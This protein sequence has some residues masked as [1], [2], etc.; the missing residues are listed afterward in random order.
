MT[1]TNK[2][3][4]SKKDIISKNV[5]DGIIVDKKKTFIIIST[6]KT[7]KD[8]KVFINPETVYSKLS[9]TLPNK[10]ISQVKIKLSDIKID[11]EVSL[12][13]DEDKKDYIREIRQIIV[14]SDENE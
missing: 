10:V 2:I 1:K 14:I 9:M 13:M 7:N 5:L 3:K 12:T 8:M 4:K 11:N 6:E